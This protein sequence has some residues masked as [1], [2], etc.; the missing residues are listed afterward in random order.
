MDLT[1]ELALARTSARSAGA[2]ALRLQAG[3]GSRPKADGSPVS[4]GDLAADA[5]VR[6]AIT[7]AFPGD[8]ILSEELADNDTRLA[9]RRLWIIDP[10]DGTRSYVAGGGEW[11]VQVALAVDGVV[12]LG[13]LDLPARGVAVWGAAGLG[14]GQA[15]A[16]GERALTPVDG[17]CDILAGG[18]SERNRAHLALVLA[19][20]P[21]FTHLPAQSV[22]VKAAQILLGEADLFVH[23]R[24]IAEWDAAAP[25]AVIAYAG[26]T[27]TD[28]AGTQLRFN[29][30]AGKVPGLVF[31]RRSDHAGLC[32]RLALA[33]L[34][35][36]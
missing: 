22:G 19:A 26:G 24:H 14:G 34:R 20:L 1:R 10:I 21:E 9:N 30:A 2:E 11:C 8:A 5:I 27:A 3:I 6:S 18:T 12:V 28:L 33:G 17:V 25:A 4:D 32:R 31:S 13:V 29:T 7:A 15:D 16:Q 35:C 36:G 23:A